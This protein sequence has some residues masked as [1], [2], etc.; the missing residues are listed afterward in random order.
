MFAVVLET[1]TDKP[2]PTETLQLWQEIV[3]VRKSIPQIGPLTKVRES[4]PH[5][6]P[7]SRETLLSY[8]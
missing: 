3:K 2:F 5:I 1:P 4:I 8:V 7:L 6:G